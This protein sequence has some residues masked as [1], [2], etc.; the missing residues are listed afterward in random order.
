MVADGGLL[1]W[2]NWTIPHSPVFDA[3]TKP[4]KVDGSYKEDGANHPSVFDLPYEHRNPVK[5]PEL[6]NK[7]NLQT[8]F[9]TPYLHNYMTDVSGLMNNGAGH[10]C[11][12]FEL[13]A[14]ECMEYYGVGQGME[15]CKDWYDDLMECRLMTK[16]RLRTQHM[17]QKRHYDNHLEYIQGKRTWAETY[18]DPP[19]FNAYLS[20]WQDPKTQMRFNGPTT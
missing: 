13:K 15:A 11:E 20:P 16:R 7:W 17:F 6:S 12:K 18:E 3:A 10:K 19:K 2:R 1:N 4:G 8:H 9:I 5:Y 14:M